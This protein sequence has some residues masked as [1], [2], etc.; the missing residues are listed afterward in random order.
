MPADHKENSP[1]TQ[2]MP[3]VFPV[4]TDAFHAPAFQKHSKLQTFKSW[5]PMQGVLRDFQGECTSIG[6]FL[7]SFSSVSSKHFFS[8]FSYNPVYLNLFMAV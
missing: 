2:H 8:L 7:S 5:P 3:E 6:L 1:R 4:V